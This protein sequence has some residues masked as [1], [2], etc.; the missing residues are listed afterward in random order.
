[1]SQD[2]ILHIE[3][4][5]GISILLVL[6]FHLE[7]PGFQYGYFGVDLFFVISGYLMA[8]LYGDLQDVP[9]VK[10]F[11]RK[12]LARILPAYF[13]VILATIFAAVLLFLPHEIDLIMK[14]NLWAAL[15]MP[16]VGFWM[17][18]A[19]FD[20]MLL[21]PLLNLWSLGVELQFYVLFPVLLLIWRR[22]NSLL[23]LVAFIS[24]VCYGINS[25]VDPK[26]AFFM[27]PGRL[28][29]FIAGFYAAKYVTTATAKHESL[30]LLAIT[31]LVILLLLLPQ[32]KIQNTFV[33]SVI[34]IA[35]SSL[36]INFGFKTG[37]EE[38]WLSSG[39]VTIGKYSYSIYLVHF[40]IIVFANYVPFGGTNLEV[41]GW[42]KLA[43]VLLAILISSYALF[44]FVE[45]KTRHRINGYQ[46]AGVSTA[47]I[48]LVFLLLQPAVQ[49]GR[50]KFA[51][52]ELVIINALEDR[53][54]YQCELVSL[55][56]AVGEDSCLLNT[57]SE[58]A[59]RF[60]L[61]GDSHA[62]AIK[63]ILLEELVLSGHSL[64]LMKG[65]QR[66]G[67]EFDGFEIIEEAKRKNV[68]VI[69][70]HQLKPGDDGLAISEFVDE[71]E[72]SSIDQ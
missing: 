55:T 43:A 67:L 62:D 28:W 26:T 70:L 50:A 16:N 44:N 7:I 68:D 46:L 24:L 56:N 40:P 11:F 19:Y 34:V 14:H 63:E 15:L 42:I 64:M 2:R 71:A 52:E 53:G 27:L 25:F 37:N 31:S 22:S 38:S 45:T 60:M 23:L 49:V 21:R 20:Y 58:S 61:A 9:T 65:Y 48:L 32:L 29:E 39:L 1:M 66:I 5:R 33:I 18:A 3:K 12:R 10:Q 6:L 59:R 36:A 57:T 35:L 13:V 41:D 8:L 30:G 69:I 54:S 47:F 51:A 4:L 72:N 17:D